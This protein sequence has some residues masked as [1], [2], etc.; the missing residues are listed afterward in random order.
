MN[1]TS[2]YVGSI[3]GSGC[4]SIFLL[5]RILVSSRDGLSCCVS[6][7]PLGDLDFVPSS[8]FQPGVLREFEE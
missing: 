8:Q 4:E 7:T 5:M 6:V 3:P 2:E 1:P